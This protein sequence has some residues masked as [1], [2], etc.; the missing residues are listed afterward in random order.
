V[1]VA[2]ADGGVSSLWLIAGFDIGEVGG[3]MKICVEAG[4]RGKVLLVPR[5]VEEGVGVVDS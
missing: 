3:G 2:V 5:E 4:E 1:S